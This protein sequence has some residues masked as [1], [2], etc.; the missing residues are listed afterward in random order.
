M[1]TLFNEVQNRIAENI[2]WLNGQVD[3]DYGQLEMLQREDEDS[4]TYPLVFPLALIEIPEVEWNSLA[5]PVQKGT[6]NLTVKIAIDCYDDTHY[7]SGTADKA[8]ERM[9]MVNEVNAMLHL[10]K[11]ECCNTVLQRTRSRYYT[12]PRGIKVYEMQYSTTLWENVTP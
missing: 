4:D 3:E 12:A 1:E 11:P 9:K 2:P 6:V 5:G 8:V 7:T 10:F